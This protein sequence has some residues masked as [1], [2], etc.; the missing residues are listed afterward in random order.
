MT[1]A[2]ALAS[3]GDAT[4]VARYYELYGIEGI[5]RDPGQR[6]RVL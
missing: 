4:A 2:T 6:P 3:H 5:E 1:F